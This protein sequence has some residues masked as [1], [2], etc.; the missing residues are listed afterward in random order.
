MTKGP[1]V[2]GAMAT[3]ALD[4]QVLEEV[5]VDVFA[6][7]KTSFTGALELPL[8]TTSLV[9]QNDAASFGV[10]LHASTGA[11]PAPDA[12]GSSTAMTTDTSAAAILRR[13]AVRCMAVPTLARWAR[14]P[15]S[16]HDPRR[17]RR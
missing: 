3:V 2:V 13:G 7:S 1:D 10:G 16:S 14:A 6:R 8:M 9:T 5:P 15:A 17:R 11:A 4:S 12:P